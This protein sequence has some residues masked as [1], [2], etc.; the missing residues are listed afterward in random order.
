MKEL[1]E[2]AFSPVNAFL[3]IMSILLIVYWLLVIFTGLDPEFF[4]IDFDGDAD[5]H[6]EH[7]SIDVDAR[8]DKHV[9][10]EDGDAGT[11]IN[12]LKFFNFDEL[13]LMFMLTILFFCMWFISV[14]VTYYF[15]ITSTLTGVLL[16][17]PMLLVSLFV[18]KLLVK[19][20]AFLYKHINHKGEPEIDF[21]GRRCMVI[22]TVSATKIGQVELFVNGDQIKVYAKSNNN[23]ELKAGQ[24]AVIVDEA[25]DKKYYL[26]E[27]FDY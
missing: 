4:S 25:S 16:L 9:H 14:N 26:I 6:V 23:E 21:L 17:L 12:I 24:E 2:I 7:G 5:I 8:P 27:K 20:L 22:S 15:N 11:F 10:N 3:S 13:P 18:V 19:P 1:I